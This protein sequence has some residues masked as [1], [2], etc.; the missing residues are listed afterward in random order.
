MYLTKVDATKNNCYNAAMK[1]LSDFDLTKSTGR[2]AARKAGFDVPKRKAGAKPRDFWSL[3]NKTEGCWLWMAQKNADGYGHYGFNGGYMRAHRFALEE[4]L[5]KSIGNLIVMHTCDNPACVRPSHLV[6]GTHADNMADKVRKNRQ[7]SGEKNGASLLTELQ[8]REMRSKYKPKIYTY[9]M[10]ANEYGVSK[11][12]V[13]KA[14][15][16]IYW[17][18]L[19]E[20]S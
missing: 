1:Q 9:K 12:T 5:G 4:S 18:Y 7:A 13:Q 10:L 2:Y 6:V 11:D 19:N 15:R 8:V 14:V 17:K 3:V 20:K 16:G